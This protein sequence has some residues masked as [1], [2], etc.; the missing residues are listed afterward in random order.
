MTASSGL[1]DS[2]S[3]PVL[4]WG[5]GRV[6]QLGDGTT[7]DGLSPGPVTGLVRGEV[8]KLSAG[9]SS[10]SDAFALALLSDGTVRSWGRGRGA[11]PAPVPG[12]TGVVDVAAGGAHALAL[13]AAGQVLAW[14]D[15]SWGQLGTNR[16]GSWR[17]APEPVLGLGRVKGVAAGC[18]FSLALLEN[19][20][21]YAWG[22]GLHGQLGNGGRATSATPRQVSGL[23]DVAAV[24]AGCQH[25]LALTWR[26]TVK[27]WGYNQYGQLGTGA[28]RSATTPVD[29]VGVED[30]AALAPGAHHTYALTSEG[31][32]LGWGHNQF[33]QLLELST[34]T[35]ADRARPV[36]IAALQGA[37]RLA[38]GSR[39]G[40]A[41]FADR[42]M[43]W[44]HNAE[45]QLGDGTTDPRTSGFQVSAAPAT[46]PTPAT[47]AASLGGNTSYLY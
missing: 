44:G 14:G 15:N 36:R 29:V 47:L 22:R 33:G 16:T 24:A 5:A 34:A 37:R 6:G 17:A 21:V 42:V 35:R 43:T 9:G 20:Q 32:V 28:T 2:W 31:A 27:A 26:A 4:S 40:V 18:D 7:A 3:E 45:G 13:E 1:P 10:S 30:I 25:A 12:L 11:V 41:V 8:A 39:H 46:P 38:A 23:T 19:G